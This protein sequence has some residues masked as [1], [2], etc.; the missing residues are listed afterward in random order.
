LGNHDAA[1]LGAALGHDALICNV[2]R[3]SLRYRRMAQVDER[4]SI[5]WTPLEHLT[6]AAYA[7]D[8]AMHFMPKSYGMRP[9][10]I[11]ARM[12]KAAAIMQFKL[13][14][15][16]LARHQEWQMEYRRLL[17]R[18]DHAKGRIEVDSV[19]YELRDKSLPT[20]HPAAPTNCQ[21]RRNFLRRL[22]GSFLSN[23]KLNDHMRYLVG[24]GSMYLIR[25]NHLI[26]HGCVPV[27]ELEKLLV[28]VVE[29]PREDDLDELWHLWS[30]P[31]SQLFGKDRIATFERDFIADKTPHHQTKNPYFAL[32]NEANFCDKVLEEFGVEAQ[33]LI[34]NGHV[35]V[36][37]KR[38]NH[39]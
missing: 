15:Q 3:V 1:W 22:R 39:R 17:H 20:I 37:T 16:M 30:G 28:C 4:Y 5:P 35:P 12:Q 9:N 10:E 19:S 11:V 34:V 21:R 36:K 13:K 25:D 8:S 14:G 33:G 27:D 38:E 23:Q 31:C 24:H 6:R 32:I 7:D 29:N 2:L 18:I 26:F